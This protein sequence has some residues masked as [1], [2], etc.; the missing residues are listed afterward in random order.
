MTEAEN[1]HADFFCFFNA[2]AIKH[3]LNSIFQKLLR[4]NPGGLC[5]KEVFFFFL[6]LS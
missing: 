6:V 1:H 2:T 4:H 3:Y 5:V